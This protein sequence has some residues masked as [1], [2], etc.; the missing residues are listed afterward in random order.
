MDLHSFY[1]S[2]MMNNYLMDLYFLLVII[3]SFRQYFATFQLKIY[4]CIV[5]DFVLPLLYVLKI[6]ESFVH[7]DEE[8]HKYHL[9]HFHLNAY[10]LNLFK[11]VLQ[12][13][14]IDL[15]VLLANFLKEFLVFQQA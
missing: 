4:H 13:F 11:I 5:L 6:V 14:V 12:F 9:L 8:I 1:Q 3:Y 2:L 10:S 7:H 15:L